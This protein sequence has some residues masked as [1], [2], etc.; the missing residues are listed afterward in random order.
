M[1]AWDRYLVQLRCCLG[2][3]IPYHNVEFKSHPYSQF[4]FPANLLP[5]RQQAV[6]ETFQF[7][8]LL[9]ETQMEL[10]LAS[11]SGLVLPQLLQA[12]GEQTNRQ[13]VFSLCL[14]ISPS[15]PLILC[16]EMK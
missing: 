15:F 10:L 8:P 6:A 9:G 12:F 4:Q 3:H 2:M 7:L 14:C 13:E 16:L 1:A 11:G 5:G